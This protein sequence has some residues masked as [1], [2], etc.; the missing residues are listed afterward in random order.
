[1]LAYGGLELA[2]GIDDFSAAVYIA[3]LSDI[4]QTG[5]AA[6]NQCTRTRSRYRGRGVN[7]SGPVGINEVL[8]AAVGL[9]AI[10]KDRVTLRGEAVFMSV[11]ADT[12][13]TG[14]AE[15]ETT[16]LLIG[17]GETGLLQKSNNERSKTAVDVKGNLVFRS[18]A[19]QSGDIIDN[20]V[21]EV[22]RRSDE[23]NGVRVDQTTD[24]ID[25]NLEVGFRARDTVQFDLEVLA[26]LD[27]GCVC[28]IWNNPAGKLAT[29]YL[30]LMRRRKKKDQGLHFRLGH[31]SLIE[32]FLPSSKTGHDNGFGTTAGGDTSTIGGTIEQVEDLGKLLVLRFNIF[33]NSQEEIDQK[34][35]LTIATTSASILRTPGKTS[36]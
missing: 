16:F 26:S 4:H 3:G 1:M 34:P 32:G 11:N 28:C 33:N 12:G 20:P 30:N 13:Y 23:K 31:T 2:S 9:A 10:E 24:C 18:K 36:G 35:R 25:I 8:V 14:L 27:K 22:G 5:P 19:R 6:S 29:V 15:I 21:R 17:R 7:T